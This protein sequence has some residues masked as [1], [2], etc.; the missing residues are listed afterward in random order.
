MAKESFGTNNVRVFALLAVVLV[1]VLL[2][3]VNSIT[4]LL[5]F[6]QIVSPAEKQTTLT[7][8]LGGEP[9]IDGYVTP[10]DK[11]TEADFV[12]LNYEHGNVRIASKHD[13]RYIYFLVEWDDEGPAWND[14]VAFYFEDDGTTHNHILDGKN[15][16][17]FRNMPAGTCSTIAGGYWSEDAN[18]WT[19]AGADFD[20]SCSHAKRKWTMEVKHILSDLSRRDRIFNIPVNKPKLMGMAVANW[21]GSAFGGS[22]YQSWNWPVDY[23]QD[24]L[25]GTNPA[26]PAT[27]GDLKVV[28]GKKP[29]AVAKPVV[30]KK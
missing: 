29:A 13:Y 7:S 10:I 9:F 20:V 21:E 22:G 8:Y 24:T 2:V 23:N 12:S 26:E 25:Y 5:T 1:A 6:K 19:P 16:Y 27:W 4:G 15:E 30:K 17:M 3:Y 18:D 14:G 11:W 28:W